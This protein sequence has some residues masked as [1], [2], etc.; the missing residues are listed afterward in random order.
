MHDW[1][2][3]MFRKYESKETIPYFE[4]V[5]KCAESLSSLRS[6]LEKEWKSKLKDREAGFGYQTHIETLAN[7]AHTL[8]QLTKTNSEANVKQFIRDDYTALNN[9]LSAI[10]QM[11]TSFGGYKIK[12]AVNAAQE[13]LTQVKGLVPES[14]IEPIIEKRQ[15]RLLLFQNPLQRL[16]RPFLPHP[17]MSQ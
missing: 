15:E 17:A 6:L 12:T 11:D 1:D 16:L 3:F 5:K 10:V 4:T 13:Q 14:V 9:E 7:F 8:D 2:M